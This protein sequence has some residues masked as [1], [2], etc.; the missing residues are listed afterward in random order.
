VLLMSVL[1]LMLLLLMLSLSPLMPSLHPS[2]STTSS[3][4]GFCADT[5]PP[6]SLQTGRGRFLTKNALGILMTLSYCLLAKT[7]K[8][9]TPAGFIAEQWIKSIEQLSKLSMIDSIK[10]LSC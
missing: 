9:V 5:S 4:S 6:S 10:Q 8:K 2:T 3:S 7:N 1:L